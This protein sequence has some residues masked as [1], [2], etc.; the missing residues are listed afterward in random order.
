M[1]GCKPDDFAACRRAH[2]NSIPMDIRSRRGATADARRLPDVRA[3]PRRIPHP[4]GQQPRPAR[5]AGCPRPYPARAHRRPR[6][7]GRGARQRRPALQHQV[8]QP[9]EA[10]A[11]SWGRRPDSN[12][13]KPRLGFSAALLSPR[14]RI[15]RRPRARTGICPDPKSGGL[16]ITLVSAI[17]ARPAGIKLPVS[18][19]AV[20]MVQTRMPYI[21]KHCGA[22]F[23]SKQ[24]HNGH[25]AVHSQ[26]WK[27]A[28]AA[29]DRIMCSAVISR[30]VVPVRQLIRHIR[31]WEQRHKTCP[32]CGKVFFA[33][34]AVQKYC[35]HRCATSHGNKQ[36]PERTAAIKAA[37]TPDRREQARQDALRA[38]HQ[39]A[40]W[41]ASRVCPLCSTTFMPKTNKQ[42]TCSRA[43]GLRLN[44]INVSRTTRGTGRV[45]G[46][47]ERT[48]GPS[49]K[50]WF[51]GIFCDSTWE[52]A[53]VIYQTDHGHS[54]TRNRQWWEY[55]DPI[56]G[57]IRKYYP[58]FRVD[59][60]LYEVK[61]LLSPLDQVKISAVPEP[62]HLTAETELLPMFNYIR[63]RYG[64]GREKL[65]DFYEDGERA[66]S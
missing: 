47:R 42:K 61:G 32:H 15:G 59:G 16:P 30:R 2:E 55:T 39:Q 60:T 53:F 1:S 14:R 56:T 5:R 23:A 20:F 17:L 38:G 11:T 54:I 65:I 10:G 37:W 50:G 21:C 43:C 12:R 48:G 63:I 35:S 40:T 62:V 6:V 28:N 3:R 51:R 27:Q 52:L 8:G 18:L 64:K 36:T 24:A 49:K 25:A 7:A 41:R 31:M 4:R 58:D 26:N 9:R 66:G 29:V 22:A 13:R 46:Y 44:G 57:L 19:D 45:G 33:T 34:E